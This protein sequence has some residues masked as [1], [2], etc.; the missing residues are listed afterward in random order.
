MDL[1]AAVAPGR[2]NLIGDHVD[3]CDGFV[4]PMAIPLYTAVVGRAAD[5][6]RRSFTN[7]FSSYFE[8]PVTILQP[9]A[10]KKG[11]G[12]RWGRYIQ[13]V[14]ALT[15]CTLCFDIV[16]HSTIPLGSGLS[17]SAA[18]ELSSY[19][20]I[21]QFTSVPLP[22]GVKAAEL[23]QRVEHEFLNVPCGIM[24]QFVISFAEYAHALRIDCRSLTFDL[25]PMSI[26]HDALFLIINSGVHH[27]HSGGEYAKRRKIVEKALS[28]LNVASWRDVTYQLIQ[29]KSS[30]FDM[31]TLD[32][33]FHVVDEI[34][35]TMKASEALLDNDITHFGRF[36]CESHHSLKEKYR[37]SCPELDELV[38]LVLSCDGVFGSRM[39]GGGFGGC[40]VS[41]VRKENVDDVK[42]YVKDNYRSGTPSF[43][44]CEPVSH[45]SA[46]QLDFLSITGAF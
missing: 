36:M 43:Y 9:Y 10:Q 4:L 30:F 14:L 40:T 8:D 45:A 25:I 34:E 42:S 23:C 19:Y 18:I 3:Y 16:V 24:D 6:Q 21:S 1:K 31:M 12:V 7:V 2:V 46:I 39:T 35:R 22:G 29:E 37:V 38:S 13:G 5:D 41:L 17:S 20:F 11:E 28:V 32:C 44:E 27:T 33:A 26:S 15:E